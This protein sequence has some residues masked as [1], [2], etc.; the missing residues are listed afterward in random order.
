ME[1]KLV[2]EDDYLTPEKLSEVYYCDIY[3]DY[4]VN[5]YSIEDLLE[6]IKKYGAVEIMP[7]EDEFNLPTIKII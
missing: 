3:D 5:L 7:P 4:V 1:F 2:I 6:L